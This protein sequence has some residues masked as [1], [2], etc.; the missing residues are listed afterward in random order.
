MGFGV[1]FFFSK[2]NKN[3]QNENVKSNN[4]NLWTLYKFDPE[5]RIFNAIKASKIFHRFSFWDDNQLE[6]YLLCGLIYGNFF[7]I[8]TH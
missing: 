5:R 2:E 1:I 3:I 7:F 4:H 6:S 8:I